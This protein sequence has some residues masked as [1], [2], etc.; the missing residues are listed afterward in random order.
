MNQKKKASKSK[1]SLK[2]NRLNKIK[3]IL[4]I[5][6]PVVTLFFIP[7]NF[8]QQ[9]KQFDRDKL[10]LQPRFSLGKS[11]DDSGN[12]VWK[13]TNNGGNISNADICPMMYMDF[14]FT[15]N[16][17]ID[18]EPPIV[19]VQLTS[20]FD[21]DAYYYDV[22]DNTFYIHDTNRQQLNDFGD[23]FTDLQYE[24]GLSCDGYCT[25]MY[26][27]LN[28]CDYTGKSINK[29]FELNGNLA[30][31]NQDVSINY[32]DQQLLEI[33][34]IPPYEIGAP[35]V[36][37]N[38]C[39]VV[40]N[41]NLA[42]TQQYITDSSHYNFYLYFLLMDMANGTDDEIG[43]MLGSLIQ[44]EDTLILRS[45]KTE[46]GSEVTNGLQWD[47]DNASYETFED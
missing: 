45:V 39:V 24:Q 27:I 4:A 9:K 12:T 47:E 34:E 46:D 19:T 38:P 35:A 44:T 40:A 26:L 41:Y 23:F 22:N 25:R 43:D 17:I 6:G 30:D 13:I 18:N 8:F 14:S 10:L 15:D 2:E 16:T 31:D 3:S 42:Q 36:F 28:Y 29:K 7:A 32:R 33:D 37:S 11:V 21:D 20:Y 1:K 5:C